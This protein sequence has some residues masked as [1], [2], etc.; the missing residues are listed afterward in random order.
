[1]RGGRLRDRVEIQ[2]EARTDNGQGGYNVTWATI[3]DGR[4]AADLVGLSGNEA[5]KAG[6]DRAVQQWRV[7]IRRNDAVTGQN[8][9]IWKRRGGDMTLDIKAVMPD[10]EDRHATLL[11]CESGAKV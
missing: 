8:R 9:L 1:M 4:V 3:A 11:L 6:I 7:K 10:P 5:M 2:A